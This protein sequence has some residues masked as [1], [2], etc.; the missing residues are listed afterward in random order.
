MITAEMSLNTCYGETTIQVEI[1]AKGPRPGTAW[2]HALH[3]LEPF[4]KISHGGAYQDST[5]L[6]SLPTLRQVRIQNGSQSDPCQALPDELQ[7]KE[8]DQVIQSNGWCLEGEI[9]AWA[10]VPEENR[11]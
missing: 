2:V 9:A 3:G 4:T 8:L 6:V 7:G 1:L 5:A 11:A 10:L